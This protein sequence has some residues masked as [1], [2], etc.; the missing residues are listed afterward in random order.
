V[1]MEKGYGLCREWAEARSASRSKMKSPVSEARLQQ[2]GGKTPP[3]AG[4]RRN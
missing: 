4:D 1:I 3:R 2:A